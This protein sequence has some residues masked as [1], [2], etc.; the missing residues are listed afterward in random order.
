MV[1]SFFVGRPNLVPAAFELRRAYPHMAGELSTSD[2]ELRRWFDEALVLQ[3]TVAQLRKDLDV[4]ELHVPPVG[5][6]AF[7]AIRKEVLAALEGWIS[8]GG[9]AFSRAVNRVDLTEAVVNAALERGGSHELAGI[10]VLRCLQKVLL[11]RHF[12]R[13]V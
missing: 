1:G 10:M 8:S 5:S 12:S 3:D 11:R 4:P 7:E 13:S 6:D 2:R 9:A